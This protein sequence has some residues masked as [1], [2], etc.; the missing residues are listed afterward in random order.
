MPWDVGTQGTAGGPSILDSIIDGLPPLLPWEPV[1]ASELRRALRFVAPTRT[2]PTESCN[3]CTNVTNSLARRAA[4][5][6]IDRADIQ[7]SEILDAIILE[8]EMLS[9][10][11]KLMKNQDGATAIEYVLIASLISVA[12]IA[13]MTVVGGK[14]SNVLSNV[15]NAMN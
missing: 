15:A 14:V 12:A 8:K 1:P 4:C 7:V 6:T 13:S 9:I 3:D 11:R 10:F 5:C 2:V